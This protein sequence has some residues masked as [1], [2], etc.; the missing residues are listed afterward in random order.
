MLLNLINKM[1]LSLISKLA[2]NVRQNPT[3]EVF[4]ILIVVVYYVVELCLE[5]VLYY[6]ISQSLLMRDQTC[7]NDVYDEGK[8]RTIK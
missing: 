4:P 6:Q 2:R 1:F 3:E 5:K 8:E 7:I